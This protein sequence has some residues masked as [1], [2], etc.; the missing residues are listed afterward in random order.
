MARQ[1]VQHDD[2]S[3]DTQLK[4]LADE[5]L[6]DFWAETQQ[7]ESL[8]QSEFDQRVAPAQDYERM[9]LHELQMR[10]VVRKTP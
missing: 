6:L 7:L 4:S 2:M 3:F 5:E 1:L 9:I 10:S 8:L